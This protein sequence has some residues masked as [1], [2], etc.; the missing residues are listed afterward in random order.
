MKNLRGVVSFGLAAFCAGIIGLQAAKAPPAPLANVAVSPT[1]IEFE[2]AVLSTELGQ[3]V[4]FG[5]RNESAETITVS[6]SVEGSELFTTVLGEFAI[7]PGQLFSFP[8]QFFPSRL[9]SHR[10]VVRLSLTSPT[11]VFQDIE[12]EVRGRVQKVDAGRP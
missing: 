12:I 1:V 3:V 11:T 6:M 2:T 9:G 8:V 5:V 7:A 4:Y 10:A